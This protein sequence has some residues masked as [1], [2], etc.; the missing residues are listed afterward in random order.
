[1]QVCALLQTDNHA[2]IFT[3]RHYANEVYA[4]AL[5]PS[6][7]VCFRL[8]QVW[9]YIE[10]AERIEL[11]FGMVSSFDTSYIVFSKEILV[12]KS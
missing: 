9:S 8:S 11:V 2:N 3:A 12:R 6:V 1:M 10:T 4:T 5:C 7:C